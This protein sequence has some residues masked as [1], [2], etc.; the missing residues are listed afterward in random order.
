ME[1]AAGGDLAAFGEVYDRYATAVHTLSRRILGDANQAED[2]LHD[3]FLEAWRN[4]RDYDPAR[5]SVRVWLLVRA[6]SRAFD[7]RGARQREWLA[8]ALGSQTAA[9]SAS[10]IW[11]Q[12]TERQLAVRQALAKLTP[13][14]RETLEL[15][16]F[17]GLTAPE[18][19]ELLGVPEGTVKSRLAR[20]LAA[21]KNALAL[22]DSDE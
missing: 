11:L 6:R 1:R 3:V 18:L 17:E 21:L 14:A 13:D 15:T 10:A 9:E 22:L 16:Y 4:L 7:R 12:P 20:G 8:C 19:S 2:L 5:G